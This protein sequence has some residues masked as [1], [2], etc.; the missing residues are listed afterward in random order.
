MGIFTA[1]YLYK[2]EEKG[3]EEKEDNL[4]VISYSGHALMRYVKLR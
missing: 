1:M 4:D 2:E 3:E